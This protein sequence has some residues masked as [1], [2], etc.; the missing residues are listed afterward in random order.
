[1][2]H[3]VEARRI[4]KSGGR[5]VHIVRIGDVAVADTKRLF[6]R[7][8]QS[9]DIVESFRRLDAEALEHAEKEK[10][11]K[12]LGRR[13]QVEHFVA[14]D[15]QGERGDLQCPVALEVGEPQGAAGLFE[16]TRHGACEIAAIEIVEARGDE[17]LQ[18]IGESRLPQARAFL[19]RGA[20][21][22]VD[23]RETRL[24]AHL[25]QL[26]RDVAGEVAGD[27][28]TAGCVGDGVFEQPRQGQAAAPAIAADVVRHL[29]AG[30]GARHGQ[31]G[32]GAAL[33]NRGA[34][35]RPVEFGVGQRRGAAAGVNGGWR[36]ARFVNQPEIIAAETAHVR[37]DDR[38]RA[39][40]RNHGFDGIAAV[41]Q[42]PCA[43]LGREVVRGDNHTAIDAFRLEH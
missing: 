31:G 16:L 34:V 14:R 5:L 42:N 9:V 10:R 38:N 12:A 3:G 21:G 20:A 36:A 7:F 33:G 13:R 39:R 43:G 32:Q 23:V 30:H 11:G 1:M 37:V 18:R 28:D 25:I 17:L 4:Q 24:V 2:R 29:P 26:A 8:D 41:A 40:R 27:R 15:L 6:G 22:Q 35:L 19:K